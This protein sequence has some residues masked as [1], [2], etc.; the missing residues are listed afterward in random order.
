MVRD[1]KLEHQDD[2]GM[3]SCNQTTLTSN[4]IESRLHAYWY[5]LPAAHRFDAG[6]EVACKRNTRGYA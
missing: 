1:L 5:Q 4:Q 2:C 6:L 3:K